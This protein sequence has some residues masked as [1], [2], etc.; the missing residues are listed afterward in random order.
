MEHFRSAVHQSELRRIP[1]V[2]TGNRRGRIAEG[3]GAIPH[4]FVFKAEIFVLHMHVIDAER[5]AAIIDRAAAGT[6]GVRQW[7]ALWKN[8]PFLF[9]GR[10][11]S[12]PTS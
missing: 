9:T 4:R 5:L 10:N 7:I 3:I 2:G 6:I 1:H 11:A 8:S 12:S